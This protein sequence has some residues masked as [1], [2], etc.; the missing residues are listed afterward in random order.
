MKFSRQ[1]YWSG[2]PFPIPRDLPDPGIEPLC[3]ASPALAGRFFST[4]PQGTYTVVMKH[5]ITASYVSSLLGHST[6]RAQVSTHA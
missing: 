1:E 2:L 3:L 6:V 5:R 4:E